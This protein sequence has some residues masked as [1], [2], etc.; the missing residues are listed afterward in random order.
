VR[1]EDHE[2]YFAE[3]KRSQ[4]KQCVVRMVIDTV[5]LRGTRFKNVG[6][7]GEQ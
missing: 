3:V 2:D 1:Y 6:K 5:S 4:S 7:G